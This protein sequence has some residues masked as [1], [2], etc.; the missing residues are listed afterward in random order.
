MSENF[1]PWQKHIELFHLYYWSPLLI[2]KAGWE[3]DVKKGM[4][5]GW[6]GENEGERESGEEERGGGNEGEREWAR[7]KGGG[8]R[9][10][11][12]V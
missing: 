8:E 6:G 4:K 2:E 1:G 12:V 9:M 3:K 10:G 7:E 11:L 5:M